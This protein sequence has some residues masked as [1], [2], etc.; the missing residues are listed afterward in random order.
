MTGPRRRSTAHGSDSSLNYASVGATES[1][2]VVVYPPR[3][4][5]FQSSRRIGSGDTRFE[6]ASAP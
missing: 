4:E 3:F 6:L 5:P 1:P 2:D